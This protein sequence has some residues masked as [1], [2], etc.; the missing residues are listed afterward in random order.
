MDRKV[1]D[2]VGFFF[3]EVHR[4]HRAAL[5][6]VEFVNRRGIGLADRAPI[7]QPIAFRP[8]GPAEH[9]AA[10]EAVIGVVPDA[11][12]GIL[13]DGNE[14]EAVDRLRACRGGETC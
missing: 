11:G 14:A 5:I 10:G 13:E 2:D 12:G 6:V 9:A 1:G 8:D 7:D 4:F 3:G